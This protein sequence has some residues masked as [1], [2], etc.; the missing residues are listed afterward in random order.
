MSRSPITGLEL[1]PPTAT[2][3][4]SHCL[5]PKNRAWG[6]VFPS[7]IPSSK[8]TAVE[9]GYRRVTLAVQCFI[10]NYRPVVRLHASMLQNSWRDSTAETVP[11]LSRRR[12][13][14]GRSADGVPIDSAASIEIGAHGS[15]LGS[16]S[17]TSAS[18]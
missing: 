5:R 10:L 8:V 13:H 6:W 11:P 3:S 12:L 4:S 15:W 7:V 1:I 17:T 2:K 9:F 14:G 16:C 18:V